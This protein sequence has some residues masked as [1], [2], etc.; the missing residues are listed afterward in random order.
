VLVPTLL[1]LHNLEEALT[2]P[3]WLPMIRAHLG[4]PLQGWFADVAPARMQVALAIVTAVAWAVALWSVRRS[5]NVTA[6]WLLLLVQ[7][8]VLLNIVWHILVAAVVLRGYT[9][10][11]VTAAFV[12]LPFS[13]YVFQLAI[14][15]RWCSAR[16]LV[17]LIPAALAV[18]GP[19][20]AGLIYL[21]ARSPIN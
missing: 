14:R 13:I 17:A 5:S 7:A 6:T 11:L 2:F 15:D 9:P 18:H 10:G 12:N 16:A 20:L 8:V 21:V 3:R 4:A 1:T 19:V